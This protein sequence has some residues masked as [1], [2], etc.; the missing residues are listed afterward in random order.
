MGMAAIFFNDAEPFEQIDKTPTIRGQMWNLVKIDWAV[1]EKRFKDNAIL[2]MY[3][4]Q[5]QGHI[6]YGWTLTMYD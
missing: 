4:A 1:S 6:T 2:Y 3:I 5:G